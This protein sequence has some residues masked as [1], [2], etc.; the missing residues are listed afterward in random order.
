[1]SV[2]SGQYPSVRAGAATLARLNAPPKQPVMNEVVAVSNW[3]PTRWPVVGVPLQYAGQAFA[4]GGRDIGNFGGRVVNWATDEARPWIRAP[5]PVAP[6]ADPW[7]PYVDFYRA[8]GFTT[9]HG[10]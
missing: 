4:A 1:M 5:E 2:A 9:S 10:Y 6:A 7:A 8:Q 3:S